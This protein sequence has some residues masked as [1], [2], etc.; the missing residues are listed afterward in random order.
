MGMKCVNCNK[1]VMYGHDVSHAKN[2]KKRLF[3]PNLH[4]ARVMFEGR[5]KRVKLCTKCLRML[6]RKKTED[7]TS[8]PQSSNP[9]VA[10]A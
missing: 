8:K 10:T 2:R 5:M 6:K 1:G 9:V 4:F 7:N 3:L